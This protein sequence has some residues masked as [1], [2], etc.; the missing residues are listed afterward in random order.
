MDTAPTMR[1]IGDNIGPEELSREYKQI[2]IPRCM[3]DMFDDSY[4]RESILTP[5]FDAVI[6]RAVAGYFYKYL[7]KY[8]ASMSRTPGDT[9]SL[10]FGVNDD[11]TISG[12][13]TLE[14]IDAN[15]IIAI[16]ISTFNNMRGVRNGAECSGV[17]TKYIREIR[18]HVEDL[19]PPAQPENLTE[20]IKDAAQLEIAY[21]RAMAAYH[22]VMADWRTQLNFYNPALDTICNDPIRRKAFLTYCEQLSAPESI[23]SKL[24]STDQIVFKLGTVTT[25]KGDKSTMD[26]WI[27]EFKDHYMSVM[28]KCR[29]E[30]PGIK[31]CVDYLKTRLS[32]LEI[33]NGNWTNKVRYQMIE[34]TIRMN[35]DP[36]EW[37][38]FWQG[39]YWV[40]AIRT[41]SAQGDPCC[42]ETFDC[43][44][45]GDGEIMFPGE[46]SE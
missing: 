25:R 45:G 42:E 5:N 2:V 30:R 28:S 36:T 18:V 26:H 40:S 33:M 9:A 4:T 17:K 19:L 43:G 46:C 21:D 16:I 20:I 3:W 41:T 8:V 37:I 22:T 7:P 13:P 12:F 6:R 10:L 35:D 24:K 38:E 44:Y 14:G 23:I 39:G 1:R 29:P 31:R 27:T 34:I 32:R 11:G 15:D